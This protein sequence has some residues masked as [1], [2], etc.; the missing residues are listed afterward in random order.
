MELIERN[1]GVGQIRFH[2]SNGCVV[3]IAE[4]NLGFVNHL[5]S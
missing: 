4:M 1:R 5:C 3:I 2:A